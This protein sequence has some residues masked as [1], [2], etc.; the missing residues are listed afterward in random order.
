MDRMVARFIV[1]RQIV[2]LGMAIVTGRNAVIRLSCQNLV[3]LQFAVFV[4][5]VNI[6]GLQEPA[7]AAAAVVIGP[8]GHHIDKVLFT[9]NRLHNESQIFCHR[10]AEALTDDLAG[11]LYREFDAQIPIP[12]GID[13][14]F[15]FTYPFG[16]ILVDAGNL[17]V[18]FYTEFFQSRP[19]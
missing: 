6:S 16:V 5:G 1:F 3:Q 14:E 10:V 9:H 7:A 11:I 2:D 19:D 18:V 12:V 13:L 8:I 15:P 17:E 4:T